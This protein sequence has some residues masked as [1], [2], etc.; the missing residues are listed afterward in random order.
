MVTGVFVPDF[1]AIF[2][3]GFGGLGVRVRAS[4]DLLGSQLVEPLLRHVQP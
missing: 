1:D 2:G 3:I 4:L